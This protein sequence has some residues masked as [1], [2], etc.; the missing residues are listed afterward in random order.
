MQLCYLRFPGVILGVNEPP[1][2]PLLKLIA[3]QL[4]VSVESWGE[5]GQREQTRRE[6]LVELQTAFG[7]QPFTMI[8]YRQAVHTLTELA[9]QT[10]K[11][12][13]LANALI[14]PCAGSRS[15]CLLSTPSSG[16]A[17]KRSPALTGASTIPWPTSYRTR[18]D[19]ASMICSS[20]ATGG[21][22][23]SG[24]EL[25]CLR[26][27]ADVSR[28]AGSVGR[29]RFALSHEQSS[30]S[31]G[32]VQRARKPR[33]A[34]APARTQWPTGRSRLSAQDRS[35]ACATA[36]IWC[37]RARAVLRAVPLTHSSST[38]IIRIKIDRCRCR[39]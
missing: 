31:R 29:P 15:F 18:I 37:A 7:F 26:R 13:V 28:A 6:H 16:R 8:H 1:F 19:A 33:L 36:S 12:I 39:F 2:P 22:D 9:M 3:D 14:E 10:D 21:D 20:A 38:C 5:Y 25:V 27:W 17:P 11:G 30:P 4:K 23:A 35:P 34:A 32:R 24:G